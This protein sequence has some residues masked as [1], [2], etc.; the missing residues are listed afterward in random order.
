MNPAIQT[1]KTRTRGVLDRV[2]MPYVDRAAQQI[3]DLRAASESSEGAGPVAEPAGDVA[4]QVP[5]DFFHNALHELRTV[6]LEGV[7]KGGRTALSVG[8]SGRWYFDWFERHV[9]PVDRHIGVEAFEPMPDDLPDYVSWL[10]ST[11]DH[12]DGVEDGSVDV[13][14]AGQTTEHLWSHELVGFLEESNR[15]LGDDGV[16]VIDSPNRLVTEH[17]HWSHGGHT[18]E[19]SA[20]E[21]T[22]LLEL[23]G[24]QVERLRGAWRCRFD[25]RVL[26]LEESMDDPA[27]VVRRVVEGGERP[28]DSFVWWIDAR[29][30]G[31]PDHDAL[32]R[33]CDELFV[34]HWDTRV[35][36]GLWPGPG[37]DGPLITPASAPVELRNLPF[38]LHRGRWRLTLRA[39]SGTLNALTGLTVDLVLPGDHPVASLDAP[40]SEGPGERSWEFDI[41]QLMFALQLVIRV[42][43]ATSDVRLAMPIE[44]VALDHPPGA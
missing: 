36:R 1:L 5:S 22:E 34:A 11:A 31:E 44:L 41:A 13:V 23:A 4:V 19:I 32:V 29:P 25:D 8:A 40:V 14:F 27:V 21:M 42:E 30:V 7:R 15:V 33:R 12:F 18:I 37:H 6:E 20:G 43:G 24:F 10:V 9:G 16:L 38:M 17:L 2:F 26:E 28:D 39:A 3:V 35:A